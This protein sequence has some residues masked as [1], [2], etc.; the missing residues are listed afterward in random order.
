MLTRLEK[1]LGM[2]RPDLAGEEERLCLLALKGKC[3]GD[4][5]YFEMSRS[6]FDDC[7][8]GDEEEALCRY[9]ARQRAIGFEAFQAEVCDELAACSGA[10]LHFIAQRQ[11]FNGGKWFLMEIAGHPQCDLATAL[12]IYWAS[13]PQYLYDHYGSV[14]RAL[15]DHGDLWHPK[16]LLIKRIEDRARNGEYLRTLAAPDLS[17]FLDAEP[18]YADKPLDAIPQLLRI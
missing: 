7:M 6:T 5:Y 2:E 15:E 16:A 18:N 14:E 10:E 12:F 3:A 9:Y 11:S 8:K 4:R 17:C 1:S 13:Q